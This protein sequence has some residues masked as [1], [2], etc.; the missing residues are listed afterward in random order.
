[1]T[2]A[3]VTKPCHGCGAELPTSAFNLSRGKPRARCRSCTSIQKREWDRKNQDHRRE[4]ARRW[5]ESG[6]REWHQ[7]DRGADPER[8]RGYGR[9]WHHAD[10]QRSAAKRRRAYEAAAGELRAYTAAYKRDHPEKNREWQGQRKAAVLRATPAWAD[11]EAIGAIYRR[12]VEL[13]RADGIAR[14]VD[15]FYP[16]KGKNVCGL[17]VERNLRILTAEQNMQKSNRLIEADLA[18]GEE[19]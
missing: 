3:L 10:P 2:E 8:Y 18:A 1:M 19:A 16:L 6:G 9:R 5:L 14:H 12:A 15:H 13:E 4:Y 11:R 17:H 7:R